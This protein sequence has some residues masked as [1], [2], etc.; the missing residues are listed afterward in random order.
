[1]RLGFA[2]A[3]ALPRKGDGS[4][5]KS[6]N[7][8]NGN[9]RNGTNN[10]RSGNG[11]NGGGY[12]EDGVFYSEQKLSSM[13]AAEN[14]AVQRAATLLSQPLQG[15][16]SWGRGSVASEF[17]GK[18]PICKKVRWSG[19]RGAPDV[20]TAMGTISCAFVTGSVF[21]YKIIYKTQVRFLKCL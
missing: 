5:G 6:G 12:D 9:G 15:A 13:E 21:V 7:N 11:N 14:T 17:D 19:G 18:C 10:S 2:R 8:R 4:N 1:M 3:R 16:R 20:H